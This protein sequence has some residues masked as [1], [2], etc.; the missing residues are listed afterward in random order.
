[1][2]ARQVEARSPGRLYAQPSDERFAT[3]VAL[4]VVTGDHGA[5]LLAEA[6]VNELRPAAPDG[7]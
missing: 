4:K 7:I 1:M 6:A 2:R 3:S 5:N